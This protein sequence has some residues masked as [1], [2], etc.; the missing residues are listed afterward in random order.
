MNFADKPLSD[1]T[2]LIFWSLFFSSHEYGRYATPIIRGCFGQGSLL[3]LW[4]YLISAFIVT[5]NWWIQRT[6]TERKRKEG[7]INVELHRDVEHHVGSYLISLKSISITLMVKVLRVILFVSTLLLLPGQKQPKPW[8]CT[9]ISFLMWEDSTPSNALPHI[10]LPLLHYITEHPLVKILA[11][12]PYLIKCSNESVAEPQN[13]LYYV[14]FKSVVKSSHLFCRCLPV[15]PWIKRFE[16]GT[17][18]L[19]LSMHASL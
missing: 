8:S 13:Y 19:V 6:Q 5:L 18:E 10:A 17:V 1:P 11:M 3:K 15:V 7:H 14:Y 16:Y 4:Q 2:N 12:P 9:H